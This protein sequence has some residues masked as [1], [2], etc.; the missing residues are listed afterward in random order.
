MRV[1][2]TGRFYSGLRTPV[3]LL[4]ALADLNSREALAGSLDVSFIGPHVEEFERDAIALGVASFVHF[5]GRVAPMEAATAAAAADVLLVIDAPS[6]GPSV[7]L[8]SK[9]IDYLPF[10]KPILGVTPEPGAS[11]RLLRRL[12]CPVASPDDIGAIGSAVASLIGQWRKGTLE[13]GASFDGVAA[14]FDIGRT[15]RLL[16]DVLIRAFDQPRRN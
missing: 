5:R 7:F 11:A 8:P 9:L 3:P 6:I 10:R 16:H 15:S 13:V 2:Y 14:E 4:R 12:G 1:V